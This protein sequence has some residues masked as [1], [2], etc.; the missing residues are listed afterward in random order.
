MISTGAQDC[1]TAVAFT[2]IQAL[3]LRQEYCIVSLDIHGAF[4]SAWWVVLAILDLTY[5][6]GTA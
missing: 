6:K 3:K 4:D 5:K 2:A 1:G